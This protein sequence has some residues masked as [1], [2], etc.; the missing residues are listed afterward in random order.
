M[1]KYLSIILLLTAA[2]LSFPND[3]NAQYGKK[4]KKRPSKDAQV[5][6]VEDVKVQRQVNMPEKLWFGLNVGNP[7]LN[8]QY[9]TLG[10][11]PMAGYKFNRFLS[12]GIIT[13]IDYTYVWNRF[14]PSEN[15][16]DY[17]IG[18]FGRGRIFRSFF[19]HA[20][21]NLTS[22]DRLNTT[23]PRT[24]FPVMLL[25]AG[26]VSGRPPWGFEA[27]LL[28]DA[29]GNLLEYRNFPFAYRLGVTYNF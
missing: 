24:N 6:G 20:E 10:L 14:G 12:A 2:M 5:E 15:Y 22:L 19:A 4:K 9:L 21:Y 23:E 18:I 1:K 25:G 27:S 26:Y 7:T 13:S 16:V 8:N 17:S 28:Y 3:M 29:T 11:G